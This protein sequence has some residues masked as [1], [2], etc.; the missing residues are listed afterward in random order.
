VG[1]ACYNEAEDKYY[2]PEGWYECNE[3]EETNW[4]LNFE[5]THWTDLPPAPEAQT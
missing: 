4:K 3:C 2:Y 1:D 5:I